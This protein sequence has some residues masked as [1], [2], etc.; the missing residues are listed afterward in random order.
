VAL[1]QAEVAVDRDLV[2]DQAGVEGLLVVEA[3]YAR[4]WR[5]AYGRLDLGPGAIVAVCCCPVVAVLFC[6]RNDVE[7]AL[8]DHDPCL[9]TSGR[10]GS[11]C[12]C[13]AALEDST[14]RDPFRQ[15]LR[16]E[17]VACS[18]SFL[19]LFGES[20]VRDCLGTLASLRVWM[21]QDGP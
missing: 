15:C 17:Q 20:R 3:G 6:H 18:S 19:G 9:R 11:R 12:H 10:C 2:V 4:L 16:L 1:L 21:V 13:N 7:A 14:R 5:V 8:E